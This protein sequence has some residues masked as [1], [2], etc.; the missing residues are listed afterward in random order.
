M[1]L[2]RPEEFKSQLLELM[3]ICPSLPFYSVGDKVHVDRRMQPNVNKP[4]GCGTITDVKKLEDGT[5]L[6]D[7]LLHDPKRKDLNV[8][9]DILS[10]YSDHLFTAISTRKSLVIIYVYIKFRLFF[11]LFIFILYV[12]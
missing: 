1:N 10:P 6:Y 9:K 2:L 3:G 5:I 7:V 8:T 4:G 12:Y 11:H